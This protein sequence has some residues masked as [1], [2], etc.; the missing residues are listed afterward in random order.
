NTFWFFPTPI[1]KHTY[2]TIYLQESDGVKFADFRQEGAFEQWNKGNN[3]LYFIFR[4]ALDGDTLTVDGG[5]TEAVK[6]LMKVEKIQKIER[7]P[8]RVPPGWLAKYLENNDPQGL[9]DLTNVQVYRRS[10]E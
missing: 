5:G 2:V 10:K 8:S 6:R 9:Y 7:G 4:Y 3:R 1:G